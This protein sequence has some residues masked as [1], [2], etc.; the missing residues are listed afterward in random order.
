MDTEKKEILLETGTNELE[1]AEFGI[2]LKKPQDE[3]GVTENAD[4][5]EKSQETAEQKNS[6]NTIQ[7]FGINVAKVREI[8]KMPEFIKMPS[9]DKNM[10]GVFKLRDKVIPLIDLAAWMNE[11]HEDIKYKDCFVIV[12]EFNQANFGFLVHKIK[13][14][15]RMSWK[16]VLPPSNIRNN[17]KTNTITGIVP[18]EDRIML[19]VDF[20]KIVADINPESSLSI[21]ADKDIIEKAKSIGENKKVLLAEDSEMVRELITGILEKGG[22]EVIPVNNGMLAW[23]Y[24]NS[25]YEESK[26]SG[27][28]LNDTL[29]IL[30]AD[31]EMPQMDGHTLCRQVKENPEMK[32]L[33]VILFS[34]LIYD[35]IRRKGEMIGA[36]AQISKPEIGN[37]LN[38]V[39]DILS[40]NASSSQ[41]DKDSLETGV[42]AQENPQI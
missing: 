24:L 40:R 22:F 29:Q 32:T 21:S 23:D 6:G 39:N 14:I 5:G 34:S 36:D 26:N 16:K 19:M 25:L 41:S 3:I 8:I 15:H 20:E 9:L 30:I 37:L 33:P 1:I 31:I 11:R 42:S 2:Y 38:V 27:K 4:S 18:L 35:E 13:T 10:L 17:M 28:N 7:T 12:T